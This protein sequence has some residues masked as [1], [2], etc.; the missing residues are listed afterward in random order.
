MR[1]ALGKTAQAGIEIAVIVRVASWRTAVP[2]AAALCRRAARAAL[3]R[4]TARGG[5]GWGKRLRARGGELCI[6]LASDAFVAKL[7][8]DYRGKTEPTNVL[9]FRAGTDETPQ[10]AYPLGDVVIAFE[11]TRR[12]AKAAG[13]TLAHHLAHLVVH[14]VLHLVGHDHEKEKDAARMEGLEIEILR[15]LGISDPY[16]ETKSAE[17]A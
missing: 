4:A 15:G 16:R 9:S 8:R 1:P 17:V 7:N 13:K 2:G 12:E 11:T 14:G 10:G 6:V 3:D 5:A